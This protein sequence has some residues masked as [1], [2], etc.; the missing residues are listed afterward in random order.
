MNLFQKLL[1]D[2]TDFAEYGSP[3]SAM[4]AVDKFVR[5]VKRGGFDED[6]RKFIVDL[7][8]R[9]RDIWENCSERSG[10]KH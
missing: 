6:E 3:E 8:L 2:I 4:L 10:S 9:W 7:L 5:I 1:C